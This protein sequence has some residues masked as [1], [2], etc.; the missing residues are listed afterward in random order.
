MLKHTVLSSTGMCNSSCRDG[1]KTASSIRW[2]NINDMEHINLGF[3][4]LKTNKEE[5]LCELNAE[6]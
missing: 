2:S 6:K 5:N 3:T 4:L 1:E